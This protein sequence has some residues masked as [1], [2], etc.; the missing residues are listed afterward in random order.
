MDS[1]LQPPSLD[2]VAPFDTPVSATPPW[3]L[4]VILCMA[5]LLLVATYVRFVRAPA[6][7]VVAV[8][9]AEAQPSAAAEAVLSLTSEQESE[10]AVPEPAPAAAELHAQPITSADTF[11]APEPLP[12]AAVSIPNAPDEPAPKPVL[13]DPMQMLTT[14]PERHLRARE[15]DDEEPPP[16]HAVKETPRQKDPG[17]RDALVAALKRD[18]PKKK[19]EEALADDAESED[20]PPAMMLPPVKPPAPANPPEVA[21]KSKPLCTRCLGS[22]FIPTK[23]IRPY[24]NVQG[25]GEPNAATSVPWGHCPLCQK[26]GDAKKLLEIEK[27]RIAAA[28]KTPEDW[29]RLS[30]LK[31]IRAETHHLTIFSE[32]PAA[33]T[34]DVANALEAVAGHLQN[35]TQR[36]LLTSTRPDSHTM[37]IT[38]GRPSY[39]K[40]IDALEKSG[41]FPGEDFALSRKAGGSTY[42]NVAFFNAHSAVPAENVAIFQFAGMQI[43]AATNGRTPAWLAEGFRAYCENAA[44]GRNLVYSFEYERNEVQLGQNWNVD[45]RAHAQQGKLKTWDKIFGVD[46]IQMK[47]IDYLTCYSMVAYL[48][49]T[50]PENFCKLLVEFRQGSPSDKALEKVYGK[51][52]TDLQMQWAQWA[53]QQK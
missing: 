28:Q 50:S 10:R 11:H 43:D 1:P 40:L 14:G 52:V 16:Q 51:R 45:I 25:G 46:L 48:L 36:T 26:D 9:A 35:L 19:P 42:K 8:A 13:K 12:P 29:S 30:G 21:A 31:L 49:K 18:A 41:K 7:N 53:L 4:P 27:Q 33:K 38:W 6:A 20:E 44:T 22:G 5:T 15:D 24:V 2:D 3:M 34:R 32:L 37:L 47:P 23:P 17:A 39:L